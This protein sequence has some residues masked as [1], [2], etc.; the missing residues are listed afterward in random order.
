MTS[1]SPAPNPATA[2]AADYTYTMTVNVPPGR[3]IEA[4]TDETAIPQWWTAVGASE[5]RGNEVRLEMGGQWL[6][7]TVER[8]AEDEVTWTVTTCE[9]APD[10]VGTRPSFSIRRGKDGNDELEFR[11]I[12]LVPSLECFDMCRAGWGHFMPSLHRYL[13][14]GEGLPNEPRLVTA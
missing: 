13:E 7:F 1:A 14:T 9:M 10:W 4:V 12:G 11:H 2:E 8:P 6:A 3:I 5:R